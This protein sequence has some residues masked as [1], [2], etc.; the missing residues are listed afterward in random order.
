[1][2]YKDM[3]LLFATGTPIV[4]EPLE[5]SVCFQMLTKNRALLDHS[6]FDEMFINAK[7]IHQHRDILTK[8]IY[9]LV[10]YVELDES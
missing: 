1:M 5:L 2:K 6:Q 8:R 3:Q 7:N 4:N 10:Q 9:G